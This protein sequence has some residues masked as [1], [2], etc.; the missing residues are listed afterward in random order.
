MIR[1]EAT[2]FGVVEVADDALIHLPNGMVG[3]PR[4][5]HFVLLERGS[6]KLVGYFQSV[7]TPA[8]A[9]PVTDGAYFPGYPEPPAEEL[10]RGAGLATADL[11]VLVIV[12]ANVQSKQLQANM[13]APL[14]IDVASRT[15][16]QCVLD[17]GKYSAAHSLAD[18]IAVVKARMEAVKR[19][20]A[21]KRG[22]PVEPDGM[23]RLSAAGPPPPASP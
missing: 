1:I 12:A 3:F 20:Q 22:E 13:L 2:R 16:A 14:I 15:G 4:E 11:A 6:G 5:T 10:A 23:A 18:P 9:F 7:Q 17:P 19:K 8:L 21:E